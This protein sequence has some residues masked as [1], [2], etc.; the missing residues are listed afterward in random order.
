M[1]QIFRICRLTFIFITQEAYFTDEENETQYQTRLVTHTPGLPD[2][3][4]CAHCAVP[5]ALS[6]RSLSL[7]SSR[8]QVL[9]R[10]LVMEIFQNKSF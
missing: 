3:G 5:P 7:L 4:A 10:P 9:F 1:C 2:A 8:L 6:G